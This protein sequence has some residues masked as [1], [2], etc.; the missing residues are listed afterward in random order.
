[1]EI[2]IVCFLCRVDGTRQPCQIDTISGPF[3]KLWAFLSDAVY[4]GS[5]TIDG[6]TVQVWNETLVCLLIK[7][8]TE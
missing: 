4:K 7:I 6:H 5:E 8:P 1:M 2:N 3:P